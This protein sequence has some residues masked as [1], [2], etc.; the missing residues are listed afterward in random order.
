MAA[1]FICSKSH[2]AGS[3]LQL[4]MYCEVHLPPSGCS[5]LL[6]SCRVS[7]HS[8]ASQSIPNLLLPSMVDGPLS[9]PGADQ[10]RFG[11]AWWLLMAILRQRSCWC[12]YHWQ[13]W[14]VVTTTSSEKRQEGQAVGFKF[15]GL[16]TCREWRCKAPQAGVNWVTLQQTGIKYPCPHWFGMEG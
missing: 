14:E 11:W 5:W 1:I 2:K 15:C 16:G 9:S 8:L 13:Q 4:G 10:A 6:S 3:C 7:L 12:Q